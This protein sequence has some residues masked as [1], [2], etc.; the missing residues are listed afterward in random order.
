MLKTKTISDM[1]GMK[2]FTDSGEY[3][4][5]VDELIISNNKVQGWKI[6]STSASYLS[7]ILGSAKG[8]IIPHQLVKAIGDIIIISKVAV[9][10]FS[11]N[12]Q[13]EESEEI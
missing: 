2:V 13:I 6:R 8:V 4:G 10:S 7:R 12:Q 9:P 1:W 3:F 5:D 11:D